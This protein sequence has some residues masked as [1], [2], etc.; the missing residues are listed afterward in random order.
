M[1]IVVYA[2]SFDP[3][4]HGHLDIIKRGSKLFDELIV[5]VAHNPEKKGLL[6]TE[7]RV[8]LIKKCTEDINGVKV[9]SFEGLT[10]NFANEHNANALLRGIRSF[11]DFEYEHQLSQINSTLN[12]NIET[13]FLISKPEYNHIS[14]SAVREL[15][16]HKC[17][18]SE[19]VPEPAAEYLYKKFNY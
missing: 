7:E 8:N 10:V 9:F 5:A 11:S 3:F 13:V 1:T 14:S 6:S 2:G 17:N 4:T 16:S 12:K 18:L 15:I 19:F